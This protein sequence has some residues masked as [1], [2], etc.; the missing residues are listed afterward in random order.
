MVSAAAICPL[1][2]GRES[3]WGKRVR[4]WQRVYLDV[5]MSRRHASCRTKTPTASK[6]VRPIQV[7][8][9]TA[10]YSPA[11]TKGRCGARLIGRGHAVGHRHEHGSCRLSPTAVGE[12]VDAVLAQVAG[13]D[14]AG[15]HQQWGRSRRPR[16]TGSPRGWLDECRAVVGDDLDAGG[17][18]G[19]RHHGDAGAVRTGEVRQAVGSR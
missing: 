9:R 13:R 3:W 7:S 8:P 4:P 11:G 19:D 16:R 6:T 18:P 1:L 2:P 10:F 17:A 5:R 12:N 15:Q 14:D